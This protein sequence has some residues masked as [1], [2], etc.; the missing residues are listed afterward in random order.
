MTEVQPRLGDHTRP[1]AFGR[2]DDCVVSIVV[3][4]ESERAAEEL[5]FREVDGAL[6]ASKLGHGDA[7]YTTA[8][9]IRRL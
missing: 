7:R 4:V 6:D 5:W 2:K 9:A 1:R 3:E 8:L